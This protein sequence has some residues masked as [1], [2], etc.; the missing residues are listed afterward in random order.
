M[1]TKA[2]Y[3][4][5]DSASRWPLLLLLV[6]GLCVARRGQ[7]PL[8]PCLDP[9]PFAGIPRVLPFTTYG[10]VTAMA[11]TAFVYGWLANAG[12]ALALWILGRLSGEP[13]RA[14]NWA[15]WARSSGTSPSPGPSSGSPWARG[16]ASTSSGSRATSTWRC[17][18]RT[19]RSRSQGSSPGRGASARCPTP[20]TGTPRPRSSSSPGSSPSAHVMLFSAPVRGVVQAIVSGWYGQCAWTLWLAPLALS[21]GLL[22][23]PEGDR[24]DVALV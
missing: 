4:P 20:R 21:V 6:S 10:R 9:A 1:T 23:R 8:A 11:Q 17:S 16:P 12:L 15:T 3:T 18:S 19:P 7:R 2:E 14:Q 13:L 22:R 5:T 24:Q